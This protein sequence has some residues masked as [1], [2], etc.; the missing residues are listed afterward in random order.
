[1]TNDKTFAIGGDLT[2]GRLGFGAMQ[3]CDTW[4]WPPWADREHGINV[5]RRA[6]ELGVTLID[7]AD[8]YGLGANEELLAEALYPYPKD[9]V[10]ATKAGQSRPS[11]GEWLPLGRPEY[12]LQQPN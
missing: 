2:V 8:S 7:T 5:A 12:L 4:D 9:L 3:L 10:I 1:M 11:R 6:V